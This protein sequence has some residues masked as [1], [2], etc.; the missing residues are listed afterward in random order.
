MR[1]FTVTVPVRLDVFLT[2]KTESVSRAKARKM[3]EVGNVEVDGKISKKPAMM[4][5]PGST[6]TIHTNSPEEAPSRITPSQITFDILYEDN[7][8]MVIDKP[9]D[10]TVHPGSG[11]RDEATLLHGLAFLFKERGLSFDE[12]NVLAHRLDKGTTGCLLVA[13]D[14]DAHVLLQKQFM[15]R[16]IEK[17]YLAVVAGIPKPASAI[18]DAPIGRST[19]DR[20]KMGISKASAQRSA[21]TTYRTLST[22]R[23]AA[24]LL[25]LPK[26]G[27]THQLRVHLH[28]I[29]H[30]IL[31]DSAYG[32]SESKKMSVA[33]DIS[34]LSLHAWKIAFMS[35]DD[36]RIHEVT[37]P[38]PKSFV[39]TIDLM[40]LEM[41]KTVGR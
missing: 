41:P 8:C 14:S 11:T 12:S 13:K 40:G 19:V 10:L 27:R 29:G 35:P 24:L 25:C 5:K 15:N 4:L 30:P 1:A 9:Q 20:K 38:V 21:Q 33:H 2:N 26:T 3:I 22:S 34:A 28:S 39:E 18:I 36:G 37:A 16:T 17:Q 7:R 31:G 6:V 23:D 32:S